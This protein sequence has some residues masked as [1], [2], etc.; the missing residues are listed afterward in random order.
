MDHRKPFTSLVVYILITL[1]FAILPS[2]RNANAIPI[3]LLL[4][5]SIGETWYICQ[6]YNGQ[7]SHSNSY[8]LDISIDPASP[9]SGGCTPS[10][11]NSSTGRVIIAPGAGN[12][13]QGTGPTGGP[14]AIYINF[15]AGGSML[16]AH[17]IHKW[18]PR[19]LNTFLG[20]V[21]AGEAI[22]TVLAP[23]AANNNYAHIHIQIHPVYN[24]PA[25]NLIP[26]EDAHQTRFQ[27]A[28]DM[29][30]SG[31]INQYSGTAL[32]RCAST[33]QYGYEYVGQSHADLV[34]WK[35]ETLSVQLR[36]TGTQAWNRD[37]TQGCAIRLG[38]GEPGRTDGY[39]GENHTSPFYKAGTYGWESNG[40]VLMEEAS[41]PPGGV[42][43]FRFQANLPSIDGLIQE[44]WTP[45]VEGVGCTV[46]QWLPS[47]G[48][49]VNIVVPP[50]NYEYIGQSHADLTL[51]QPERISVQLRNIGPRTW[52]RD[53]TQGCAIRLGT[54]E[55]GR[56]D[57]YRGE[58]HTSPFYKAGTYGWESNGRVLM[59]EA[60]VPPGGV[61]TFRFQANLPASD[62][63]IQEYWTPVVEGVGCAASQ[64]LPSIGIHV[65]ITVSLTPP[66]HAYNVFLPML[67]R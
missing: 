29:P 12:V 10:T 40:R 66:T 3:P 15:D 20:Y 28:P 48:I 30:Y 32:T 44:Y 36:N 14:D 2:I 42:G 50:F 62:G 43:T 49:H 58:N 51:R 11:G 47:I 53:S 45:V 37:S 61:A 41:V 65:N 31:D 1:L 63:L 27:C 59:E 24:A 25:T 67:R 6:G 19:S 5:F 23:S 8:A 22:G 64:W 35:P 57:G 7:I 38:T 21:T 13:F 26:F 18:V 60:S 46:P 54:G 17:M 39:R 33:P 52:N 55:P 56:T 4:P 34:L 9:G 16:L